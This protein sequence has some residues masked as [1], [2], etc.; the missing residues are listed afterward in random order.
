MRNINGDLAIPGV[1]ETRA[2]RYEAFDSL[3]PAIRRMLAD[4]P[5]DM[6]ATEFEKQYRRLRH[7]GFTDQEILAVAGPSLA[8]VV[9]NSS[10]LCYGPNHPQAA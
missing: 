5:F 1:G 6:S 9:K 10:R 7:N 8:D 3:P 2:D 4:A